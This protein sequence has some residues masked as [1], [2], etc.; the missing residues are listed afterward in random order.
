M[1][2]KHFAVIAIIAA[3][4]ISVVPLME[5]T[6]QEREIGK[7]NEVKYTAI[8]PLSVDMKPGET[9]TIP[10]EIRAGSALTVDLFISAEGK[11]EIARHNLDKPKFTEAVSATISKQRS[12]FAA[13]NQADTIDLVVTVSEDAKPGQYPLTLA[14][15]QKVTGGSNLVQQYLYVN[16]G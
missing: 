4:T 12:S 6:A 2:K 5:V 9:K 8:M 10:V 14:M 3:A 16:V 11:E 7:V 15:K 1:S 13:A